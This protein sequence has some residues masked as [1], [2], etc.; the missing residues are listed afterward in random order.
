MV[1]S[2]WRQKAIGSSVGMIADAGEARKALELFADPEG[3][4]QV[5]ALPT[6]IS[7]SLPSTDLGGL[8][9]AASD[10]P[11]GSGVYFQINPVREG[12]ASKAK[13]SDITRRRWLLFDVDPLKAEGC[14]KLSAT[15]AEKEAALSAARMIHTELADRNWPAPVVIDSGNGWYL[16]YRIELPND[17]DSRKLVR[18]VLYATAE[19]VKD[20]PCSFDK[21]VHNADRLAKLPGSWARKGPDSDDRPHR[22]ARIV[23]RPSVI[24]SV[25]IEQ[26][27]AMLPDEER[28]GKPRPAPV[29]RD[30]FKLRAGESHGNRSYAV[31]ALEGERTK[32]A[33]TRPGDRDNQLYR[34]GA[35]LGEL[36]QPGLLTEVEIIEVLIES[37]RCC[38][39]L[40][41]IS[42]EQVRGKLARSIAK[43]KSNP[44]V[45]PERNGKM[46]TKEAPA[47]AEFLEQVKTG[48][49]RLTVP[50]AKVEPLKVD[51]LVPN[52]IPKRFITVFAGRTGIGKSFV[53]CDII[54]RL[55]TGRPIPGVDGFCFKPG[56]VLIISEDSHEYVLAPRLIGLGADLTRI[57]AMTWEAMGKYF[58]GDTDMLEEACKEVEDE[59]SLVMI[60]PPTNFLSDI[61]EHK[62]SEVRQLVMKV[63]EWCFGHDLACL[64]VLHINK[65]TGKGVEA[66]NRVMGSV[67]WVTT[68]RIAHSFCLDPDDQTRGLW[69]PTKNNL[70]P[71]P[72]GLAYR[73]TGE[74]AVVEWLGEVD[75]TA[76]EALGAE[77]K[78]RKRAVVASD[79]LIERF[80]D[81]REWASDDLFAAARSAGMS[82]DAIFAAKDM[83]KLPKARQEV[84]GN[85]DKRWVWWVPEDWH[86]LAISD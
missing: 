7:R 28:N 64:F 54:A 18:G 36:V 26:L 16:I 82:R 1:G 10:M 53:A 86:H 66:I 46:H 14:D 22:P 32:L 11:G 39:L 27:K 8:V 59:V 62:N 68:S 34:S 60:D 2:P 83:L 37:A 80:R 73:I 9:K 3:W 69:M 24:E 33:L 75:M 38:G 41:D 65:Q 81:K 76:D 44:R 31:A 6:A 29:K 52:R 17:E 55:T 61:D 23:S 35:A 40:G 49:K 12:L 25:T 30:P 47:R 74:P 71:L 21:S 77:P 4:C 15:D 79:W 63:V 13:A 70:G 19:L 58:L 78:S 56:G 5:V 72:K 85:G 57:N 84:L 50:L 48:A 43:G 20:E 51:W 42:E 67:A 45:I